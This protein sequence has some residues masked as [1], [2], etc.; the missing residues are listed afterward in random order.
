M[1]K[2]VYSNFLF[3][4]D[5]SSEQAPPGIISSALAPVPPEIADFE[6]SSPEKPQSATARRST[7]GSTEQESSSEDEED[8][9]ETPNVVEEPVSAS[10]TGFKKNLS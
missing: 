9:D 7:T 4:P 6:Y 2:I 5:K 10:Q 1:K 3:Q 8:E